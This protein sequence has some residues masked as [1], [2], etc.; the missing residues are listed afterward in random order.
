MYGFRFHLLMMLTPA[1]ERGAG[2]DARK[3]FRRNTEEDLRVATTLEL[4]SEF[5]V[6]ADAELFVGCF[7]SNVPKLLAPLR[8]S[9]GRGLETRLTTDM[10]WRGWRGYL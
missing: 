8:A 3:F 10:K 5:D 4:L 9:R 2:F 1:L 7:S 6:M